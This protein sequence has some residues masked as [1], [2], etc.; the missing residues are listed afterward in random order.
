MTILYKICFNIDRF[1][2]HEQPDR[3]IASNINDIIKVCLFSLVKNLTPEDNIVFFVDGTDE[4]NVIYNIC[5]QF[6]VNYK[7]Y[8][9]N[10]NC[11]AKINNECMLY[12]INNIEDENEIIYLCEDDYLHYNNCLVH[13]KDFIKQYPDF[14]CH[15]VDY[16]D[17][18]T[19]KN[20]QTSE[21]VLSKNKHWRSVKTTTYTIAFTKK[22]FNSNY[23]IFTSINKSLFYEHIINLI[24]VSTKCFSPIPSLISHIE[25]HCLSPCI[26]TEKIFYSLFEQYKN[27]G[28]TDRGNMTNEQWSLLYGRGGYDGVGSGPGSL[29]KN[30][31]SLIDWLTKFIKT[32]NISTVLDL[33]CG[34]MQWM[35]EVVNNTLVNYTGVD[36]VSNLILDHKNKFQK[37]KFLCED[38]ISFDIKEEKYDLI[39]S[40]DVLQH[41]NFDRVKLFIDKI[42]LSSNKHSIIVTPGNVNS[43]TENYLLQNNFTL[44][45]TYQSD[46]IKKI[47]C[48]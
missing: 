13:I 44:A 35:P 40:K 29:L 42:I 31:H 25:I 37:L 26:D 16:P 23:N 2:D 21:I 4:Q 28:I 20:K 9:F 36:C 45:T 48:K 3:P 7:I 15:P 30:N 6:N 10:H 1:R 8:N 5:D 33:G 38:I 17:L 12:I 19:N 41:F 39:F 22:V 18:Y 32:N 43:D 14:I 46:E 27:A 47:F 24:Y 11:A 34:D